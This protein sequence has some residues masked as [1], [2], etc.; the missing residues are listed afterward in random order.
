MDR[1]FLPL[2]AVIPRPPR[3]SKYADQSP[4]MMVIYKAIMQNLTDAGR[5]RARWL[6]WKTYVG[7]L[8]FGVLVAGKPR[9]WCREKRPSVVGTLGWQEFECVWKSLQVNILA[10]VQKG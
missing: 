3:P 8:L 4:D 7:F 6:R 9:R 2:G 1:Y 5:P 10:N